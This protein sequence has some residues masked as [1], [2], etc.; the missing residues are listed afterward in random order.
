ML[1]VA[2]TA[3]THALAPATG[4]TTADPVLLAPPAAVV[5][6]LGVPLAPLDLAAAFGPLPALD[7]LVMAP[8]S[9]ALPEGL[10]LS[11]AGVLSGTP[12]AA[13][14][15]LTLRLE[16]R[17]AA[18]G[19][20]PLVLPFR[21]EAPANRLSPAS[22]ALWP[23]PANIAVASDAGP[24]G[25]PGWRITKTGTSINQFTPAPA[26]APWNR[27]RVA[28]RKRPP[29][30]AASVLRWLRLGDSWLDLETGAVKAGPAFAVTMAPHPA[31]PLWWQVEARAA[32][33]APPDPTTAQVF[34]KMS[35]GLDSTAVPANN[36]WYAL[37]EPWQGLDARTGPV[38]A[39]GL[40]P[41]VLDHGTP[42]VTSLAGAFAGDAVSLFLAP[43][44]P[45]LPRGLMLAGMALAGTPTE[46]GTVTLLLGARNDAGDDRDAEGRPAR[47]ALTLEVRSV[48]PPAALDGPPW[49]L[50]QPLAPLDLAP[51]FAFAPDTV[52][53]GA[54]SDLPE[55]VALSGDGVLSGTPAALP[56]DGPA[57]YPVTVV[58]RTATRYQALELRVFVRPPVTG[59]AVAGAPAAVLGSPS[60]AAAGPGRWTITRH[61]TNSFWRAAWS[62][63]SLPAGAVR[64]VR[65]AVSASHATGGYPQPTLEYRLARSANGDNAVWTQGTGIAA[66]AVD[67]R[68][69]EVTADVAGTYHLVLMAGSL[70]AGSVV[71]VHE[72]SVHDPAVQAVLD[73][74]GFDESLPAGASVYLPIGPALYNAT[75]FALAPDSAPLPE[76]LA[77]DPATGLISG[78][79]RATGT[80]ALAVRGANAA[81]HADRRFTLT[82]EEGRFAHVSRI[83]GP[84]RAAG[85]RSLDSAVLSR[86]TRTGARSHRVQRVAGPVARAH[87]R[88]WG[89]TRGARY[90]LTPRLSGPAGTAVAVRVGSDQPFATPGL[91][92]ALEHGWTLGQAAPAAL[93][94]TAPSDNPWVMIDG[95]VAEGAAFGLDDLIVTALPGDEAVPGGGV[96]V[97]PAFAP[98]P[99][100]VAVRLFGL[101]H[102]VKYRLRT[103]LARGASAGPLALLLTRDPAVTDPA[104]A[105]PGQPALRTVTDHWQGTA[106]DLVLDTHFHAEAEILWLVGTGTGAAPA[107]AAPPVLEALPPAHESPPAVPQPGTRYPFVTTYPPVPAGPRITLSHGGDLIGTLAALDPAGGQTILLGG[108]RYAGGV[109]AG[110]R[111][112]APVTVIAATRYGARIEGALDLADVRNLRLVGLRQTGGKITLRNT[113][114]ITLEHLLLAPEATVEA[115]S[116][117]NSYGL[118]LRDIDKTGSVANGIGTGAT[119]GLTLNHCWDTRLVGA[120]IRDVREDGLRLTGGGRLLVERVLFLESHGGPDD[121][122]DAIQWVH[123]SEDATATPNERRPN[124]HATFRANAVIDDLDGATGQVYTG[125]GGQGLNITGNH[126]SGAVGITVENN[127]FS[128][129]HAIT[130]RIAEAQRD[131]VV[132]D[133][134]VVRERIQAVGEWGFTHHGAYLRNIIPQTDAQGRGPQ[135][136]ASTLAGVPGQRPDLRHVVVAGNADFVSSAANRAAVF[137]DPRTLHGFTVRPGNAAGV[138]AAGVGA[139]LAAELAAQGANPGPFEPGMWAAAAQPGGVAVTLFT[140]PHGVDTLAPVVEVSLDGG[141]WAPLAVDPPRQWSA[142]VPAAPG[143][144]SLRVRVRTTLPGFEAE[145]PASAARAVTVP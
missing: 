98:A 71:T 129:N 140:W 112:A 83:D 109:L 141:A 41:L 105:W 49:V 145:G 56:A 107:F 38:T 35:T 51:L 108:G 110:K 20:T 67:G 33:A 45:P 79:P 137:A 111:F 93:A 119:H 59:E 18:G 36:T 123:A 74:G 94:F 19:R 6:P 7:H 52:T 69:V 2:I 60:I 54:G 46:H 143:P 47:V 122:P 27:F 15:P 106:G 32:G 53:L 136:E 3:T 4:Q 78:T 91:G 125:G 64:R 26:L 120:R 16:G 28:L 55:G 37:A 9:D 39:P 81:G 48:A 133:N 70:P 72:A 77:L 23:R 29:G 8:G 34:L 73:L 40:P 124:E 115:V 21:V 43:E 139:P 58:A 14:Q 100:Q 65:L 80:H 96:R 117:H 30:A 76:G 89:L 92:W 24:A 22:V 31:D 75:S 63:G 126:R 62:L 118:T 13:T 102:G 128:V 97:E 116:F 42:A 101:K 142:S 127:L 121:H 61:A 90:A 84:F 88:L 66:G 85:V 12:R 10:S 82:I 17:S 135:R 132:R 95:A 87:W 130:L 25:A 86:V 138:T 99:G 50:G 114:D 104:A 44:S 103:T 11:P 144:R 57:G 5:W 134:T 68:I 1:A 113:R 131:V